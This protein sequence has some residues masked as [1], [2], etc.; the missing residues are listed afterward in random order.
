LSNLIIKPFGRIC[1]RIVIEVDDKAQARV[2]SQII[3]LN[4]T[5]VPIHPLQVATI[6]AGIVHAN[7]SGALQPTKPE[8]PKPDAS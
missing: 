7:L 4:G 3:N 8:E 5:T 6:L 2:T 1:A